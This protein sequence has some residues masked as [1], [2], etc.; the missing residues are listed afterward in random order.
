[1]RLRSRKRK[2][3]IERED[4]GVASKSRVVAIF[5]PKPLL[6]PSARPWHSDLL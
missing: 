2:M 4:E 3:K 6:P 5:I 1:M